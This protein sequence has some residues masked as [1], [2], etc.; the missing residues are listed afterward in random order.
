MSG[1]P[2]WWLAL[3]EQARAGLSLGSGPWW[4]G[5]FLCGQPLFGAPELPF[6]GPPAALLLG[7]GAAGPACWLFF[8]ALLL[9]S[10][11]ALWLRQDGAAWGLDRRAAG[12]V[13]F[14]SVAGG[15]LHPEA[16]ALLG[17]W[18]WLPWAL[19][20]AGRAP[21]FLAAPFCALLACAGSPLSLLFGVFGSGKAS[22][23]GRRWAWAW[24]LG[25]ALAAPA[26]LETLR[27]APG[28]GSVAFPRWQF[29]WLGS[30]LLLL[31]AGVGVLALLLLRAGWLR[32]RERMALAL[33][34]AAL[35]LG[36]PLFSPA[37]LRTLPPH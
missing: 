16:A 34:A 29:A 5:R 15:L 20:L 3:A 37:S 33:A 7:L 24:G 4:S 23:W 12:W 14:L 17:V 13:A 22:G 25:L 28:A 36:G 19:L 32:G 9:S 26:L 6:G 31:Q 11:L 35:A 27:L 18:A 2:A 21:A 30:P 1:L 10:G 8:H